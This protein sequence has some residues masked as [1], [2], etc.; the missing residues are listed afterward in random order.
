M[1]FLSD[2]KLKEFSEELHIEIGFRILS[3][4][5]DA[6]LLGF[7]E[8]VKKKDISSDEILEFYKKNIPDFLGKVRETLDFFSKNHK[9][10]I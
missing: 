6:T 1:T 7:A 10:T 4:M 5:D 2:N 3:E 9:R 8:L